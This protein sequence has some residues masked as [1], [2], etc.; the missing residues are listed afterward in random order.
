LTSL[1]RFEAD[2]KRLVSEGRDL[3]HRLYFDAAQEE[4][5]E[6]AD[7]K[8]V[9]RV[10]ALP[11][12]A[13]RYQSWYSEAKTAV[14]VLLPQ[15]LTDFVEL[16]ERPKTRRELD[17][18][19]YV[20]SDFLRGIE[21]KYG[22]WG[23]DSAIGPF[24]QQL[25]I[26]QACVT[27]LNSSLFDIRELAQADLFASELDAAES[28]A[29]SGFR[30]AAGAWVGVLLER[31]LKSVS[32]THELKLRKKSPTLGDY[33]EALKTAHVIDVPTWRLIQHLADLRNLAAHEKEREPTKDEIEDL[34]AG[35][36]K[37]IASV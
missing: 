22:H 18:S 21:S 32:A 29:R 16:Y 3:L 36:R 12:F 20:I 17:A 30:R 28:L 26:V 27:R 31:H 4:F 5:V 10:S 34:I 6:K 19:N 23:L 24:Q 37:I 35:V 25:Y 1:Q 9:E 15:R 33:N 11:R 13:S 2:L 7:P 14:S 8:E